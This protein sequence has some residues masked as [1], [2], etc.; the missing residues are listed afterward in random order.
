MVTRTITINQF[1]NFTKRFPEEMSRSGI[2]VNEVLA[3]SLQQ[4]ARARAV[5]RLKGIQVKPSSGKKTIY[6]RYPNEETG[7]IARYVDKGQHPKIIPR[8][9]IE[10]SKK[11]IPTAGR[12]ARDVLGD[13]ENPI[14]VRPKQ[15]K[16]KGFLTNSFENLKADTPKVLEREL[17]KT[18]SKSLA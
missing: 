12:P 8:Q 3:K 17:N 10:A 4:R 13:L 18:I 11:G 14:F 2:R 16:A 7:K 9:L 5:G 1:A 15:S 6:L